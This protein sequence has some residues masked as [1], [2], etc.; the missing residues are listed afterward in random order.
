MSS[1][2]KTTTKTIRELGNL[3]PIGI[4]DYLD[5]KKILKK[6]FQLRDFST[7]LEKKLGRF[8][9]DMAASKGLEFLTVSKLMSMLFSEI[10]GKEVDY[11]NTTSN[12]L[13]Q[14]TQA[15]FEVGQLYMA[16][17]FYAYC[18]ARINEMG[19]ET[20]FPLTC[21]VCNHKELIKP[22]L[23]TMDVNSIDDPDELEV[24]V[25]LFHGFDSPN[26]GKIKE[27]IVTPQKW[28]DMCTDEF[29]A[30]E[31]DE[32]LMKLYFIEKTTKYRWKKDRKENE[33]PLGPN[34][35]NQ[36]KKIDREKIANAINQINIGAVFAVDGKCPKCN[37][38]FP[39]GVDWRYD[40]FFSISSQ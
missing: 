7:P 13:V 5:G 35:I 9:A 38:E 37:L 12:V 19:N 28:A 6:S 26:G 32:T 34:D 15:L 25:E 24:K 29:A 14:D 27:V 33:S 30:C 18:V 23:L 36:L 8:R 21:P 11:T 40:D 22:D 17:V 31:G 2:I 16:D 3:F 4:V 10:G 39:I 1:Q 20:D